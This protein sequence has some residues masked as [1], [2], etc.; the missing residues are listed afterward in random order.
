M[1]KK[2]ESIQKEKEKV[3]YTGRKKGRK[4]GKKGKEN[5]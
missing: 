5:I 1:I 4:R 2:R 3:L